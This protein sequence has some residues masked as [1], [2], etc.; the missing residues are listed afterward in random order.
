MIIDSMKPLIE[1]K[2]SQLELEYQR[3][4]GLILTEDDLK[5]LMYKKFT[6]IPGLNERISTEDASIYGK[7]IHSEIPW[8]DNNNKLKIKPDI[9][10][11]EPENMSILHKYRSNLRLPSKQFEFSGNAIIFELKFIRNKTGISFTTLSGRIREDFNKMDRLFKRFR[12]FG[13]PHRVFC[14]FVIFNKTNRK[15]SEFTQFLE[16][17]RESE[18]GK[19]IYATGNV[20]F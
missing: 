10:I 19:L 12:D 14:Y 17:N 9:T 8:Y 11:L 15:C 6:E 1:Q 5:C 20:Q 13:Y 7:P 16:Q 3:S 18:I 2:I 4:Q